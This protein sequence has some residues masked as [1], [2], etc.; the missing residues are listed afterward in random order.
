MLIIH[1]RST[2]IPTR[3]HISGYCFGWL[4]FCAGKFFNIEMILLPFWSSLN[5]EVGLSIVELACSEKKVLIWQSI[6]LC[7]FSYLF[8]F[9][10]YEFFDVNLSE[11]DRITVRLMW[12]KMGV[13]SHFFSE[14][15]EVWLSITHPSDLWECLKLEGWLDPV[16]ASCFIHASFA[17]GW[18]KL[19]LNFSFCG[20]CVGGG[21]RKFPLSL[22]V[23]FYNTSGL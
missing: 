3:W 14:I 8:C 16:A 9:E 17:T 5:M 4:K 7:V 11:Q 1:S 21:E 19:F 22:L 20:K 15:W 12:L 6:A 23:W 10:S 13:C 18:R 2:S